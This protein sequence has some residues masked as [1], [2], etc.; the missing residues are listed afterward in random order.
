M[1]EFLKERNQKHSCLKKKRKEH[2][3]VQTVEASVQCESGVVL[4]QT[5]DAS[6]QTDH[7]DVV[8]ELKEQIQNLTDVVRQLTAVKSINQQQPKTPSS[9]LFEDDLDTA[10]G[11]ITSFCR[12]PTPRP[13]QESAIT[14]LESRPIETQ[15][16]SN[17]EKELSP[18]Y[19]PPV[20]QPRLPLAS[21]DQNIPQLLSHGPTDEQ[22]CKVGAMVD[23]GDDLST[24]ALACVDVLFTDDEMA[25]GNMSGSKGYQ[26]LDSTKMRFLISLLRRK[27][28]S[29]S[30]N[31]QWSEIAARINTK[32]RGKRRTLIQRLKKQTFSRN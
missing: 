19:L 15:V 30:F 14:V 25:K 18:I 17:I 10:M 8:N 6:V 21:V 3:K 26:Q 12:D 22:R 27:F 5:A 20:T 24:T 32:C 16:L 2:P 7:Y 13:P 29:S 9:P 4:K 23:L 11:V 31:E 1:A 28:V